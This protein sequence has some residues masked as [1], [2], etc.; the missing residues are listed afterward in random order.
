M[1]VGGLSL[2][3][4]YPPSGYPALPCPTRYFDRHRHA[5]HIARA[6]TT[7]SPAACESRT[8]PYRK[9]VGGLFVMLG[10]KVA[11]EKI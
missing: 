11:A 4:A 9:A 6:I 8:H 7:Q 3:G 1:T 10:L 2:F 5:I